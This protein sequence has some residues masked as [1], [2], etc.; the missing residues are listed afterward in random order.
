MSAAEPLYSVFHYYEGGRFFET[1]FEENEYDKM[2]EFVNGLKFSNTEYDVFKG[3]DLYDIE[4]GRTW[5]PLKELE[6]KRM[7]VDECQ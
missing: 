2:I 5:N 1:Q 6:R 3:E 4:T 7:E